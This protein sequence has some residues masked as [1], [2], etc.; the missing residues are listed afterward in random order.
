MYYYGN[1]VIVTVVEINLHENLYTKTLNYRCVTVGNSRLVSY[2]GALY[3]V[4]GALTA[5]LMHCFNIL[6]CKF[7]TKTLKL[8]V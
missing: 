6:V 7:G 3:G 5:Y 8:D 4:S 1:S 2:F